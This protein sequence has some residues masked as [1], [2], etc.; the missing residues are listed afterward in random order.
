MRETAVAVAVSVAAHVVAVVCVV[1]NHPARAVFEARGDDTADTEDDGTAANDAGATPIARSVAATM[2]RVDRGGGATSSSAA[3][4]IEVVLLDPAALDAAAL[5]VAARPAETT[6]PARQVAMPTPARPPVEAV[7]APDTT[8]RKPD[9]TADVAIRR[10]EPS[11][12]A[13]GPVA[14]SR[15]LLAM[16]RPSSGELGRVEVPATDPARA[17]TPS[18]GA[19]LALSSDQASAI[20]ARRPESPPAPSAADEMNAADEAA[21]AEAATLRAEIKELDMMLLSP[22]HLARTDGATLEAERE[23]LARKK[24]DLTQMSIHHIGGGRYTSDLNRHRVFTA[25]IE[26]DGTTHLK[27]EP[28]FQWEGL[29][30]R[31]DLTDWA[32]RDF[33]DDPYQRQKMRFL[34]RTRQQRYEIGKAYR[35]QILSHSADD[36]RKAVDRVWQTVHDPA[37]Q[38]EALF[39]LW[40]DCA[41]SGDPAL[42]EAGE[43][44][45]TFVMSVIRTKVT[46]TAEELARFNARRTSKAR[47]E[48]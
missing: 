16:R 44:A 34:D 12:D 38:R 28:N 31:F 4:A 35:A 24:R 47:F 13:P 15:S 19:S 33:G 9:S 26:P 37:R 10:A 29:G 18:S 14:A 42:V 36:M 43:V 48:P 32:M 5:E 22:G 21:N 27:D 6:R 7:R 25:T 8:V 2:R 20:L 45:R 1:D 11:P 40:D 41:E 30:F 23:E 17:E 46:Y 39:E 3:E